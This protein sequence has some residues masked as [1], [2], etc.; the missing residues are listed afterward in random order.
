MEELALGVLT[1]PGGSLRDKSGSLE[2]LS[3][4]VPTECPAEDPF[5]RIPLTEVRAGRRNQK[6][7]GD[8]PRP[9]IQAGGAR[10]AGVSDLRESWPPGA[11]V[12]CTRQKQSFSLLSPS[13][14]LA[15]TSARPQHLC[16]IYFGVSHT[17]P[18][19]PS[20]DFSHSYGE[21]CHKQLPISRALTSRS[22][23]SPKAESPPSQHT[24]MPRNAGPGEPP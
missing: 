22:G 5:L 23:S 2:C 20:M 3:V 11:A 6:G 12:I 21:L 9:A 10:G 13:D 1:G 19:V 18:P 17:M 7:G 24:V 15:G 8:T 14:L 16:P 4:R